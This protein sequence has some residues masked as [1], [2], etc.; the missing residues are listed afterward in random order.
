[1]AEEEKEEPKKEA[2]KQEKFQA[3]PDRETLDNLNEYYSKVVD[4]NDQLRYVTSLIKERTTIEKQSMN[5]S[6]QL[7]NVVQ[8]LKGSYNSVKD[9]QNDISKV[10]GKR[11]E[12][13]KIQ[14]KLVEGLSEKEKKRIQLAANIEKGLSNQ[15]NELQ[16][17]LEADNKGL[18]I[19]QKRKKELQDNI[20]Q[21]EKGLAT[22]IKNMSVEERQLYVTNKTL[23]VNG[24]IEKALQKELKT[25]K[26]I[27]NSMGL[28]GKALKGINSLLGGALGNTDEL[29]A[30][31]NKKLAAL[32]KE[33]KL[34]D[35]LG[36]KMQG[37]GIMTGEVGKSMMKNLNDPLMYLKAGLEFD[38]QATELQKSLALS[39][40]EAYALRGELS[41]AAAQSG[42]MA[43]NTVKVQKAFM[44]INS[45]LGLASDDFADMAV[46]AAIMQEKIGLTDKAIGQAAKSSKILG[47]DMGDIKLDI[48]ESTTSIRT[49]T[50]VALDYK[51]IMEKTL[52]VTGQ[53]AM[54]LG[55]NPKEIAKAVAQ[56]KALGLELEQVASIGASLLEFESSIE[57][58]L[59]AELLT[60]KQLNLEKAR[61]AALT[62]DQATLAKEVAEQ[63]GSYLDFQKMN[64][65][66]QKELAGAF[67]M[68]ADEMSNMMMD[69]EVMGKSAKQLR[70][71]GKN[72]IADRLEARDAQQEFTDAVEKMKGIFVDL[73]GGPLGAMLNILVMAMQPIAYILDSVSSIFG[74]FTGSNEELTV[75]QTIVGAIAVMYGTMF[76]ITKAKLVYDKL[77]AMWAARKSIS[78]AAAAASTL[79]QKVIAVAAIP[80]QTALAAITG[81]KAVAE[82]SAA[83]ALTLGLGVAGIIAGIAG[84]VIYMKSAGSSMKAE[85]GGMIGGSRHSQGGTMIEAEQGE[86]IMS[87]KGV[88]AAGADNLHAMNAGQ[89]AEAGGMVQAAPPQQSTAPIDYD[90]L[91]GAMSSVQVSSGPVQFDS[92]GYR[93]PNAPDG[94]SQNAM[95]ASTKF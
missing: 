74:L 42:D 69:Q 40:T 70:A 87:R 29:L 22:R 85:K 81:T 34:Q 28:S 78:E 8:K 86:F 65:L 11:Q 76:T 21:Q 35:G 1:M 57:S 49:Q 71:E 3:G 38:K 58:E 4:L 19:D 45:Q 60:G 20:S 53:V 23:G 91:A 14:S 80:I 79:T 63:A 39:G 9:V 89:R 66:Q 16:S 83:S 17:M 56:A 15:K 55:N 13:E 33:D 50:G 43:I 95:Q 62:G 5:L 48:I 92:A 37:F 47:R 31:T 68:G 94:Q 2:P 84:M 44:T 25:Q 54:N 82:M 32:E 26:L 72:E 6:N 18:G 51:D 59:K 46:D 7:V 93:N 41:M 88:A 30:S 77:A 27:E 67:G 75:M 12:L 10:Q 24:D 73:V 36:G 61:M 64:V 52:N 90:A